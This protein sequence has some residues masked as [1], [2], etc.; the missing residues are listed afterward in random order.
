MTWRA[1][2][3][4]MMNENPPGDVVTRLHAPR[5]PAPP[6]AGCEDTRRWVRRV[7]LAW[8]C[9]ACGTRFEPPVERTGERLASDPWVDLD[10]VVKFA[11]VFEGKGLDYQAI[12]DMSPPGVVAPGSKSVGRITELADAV[13]TRHQMTSGGPVK[14]GRPD[15]VDANSSEFSR[16]VRCL[17]RLDMMAA[18]AEGSKHLAVLMLAGWWHGQESRDRWGLS[19]EDDAAMGH[20]SWASFVE[21]MSRELGHETASTLSRPSALGFDWYI[22]TMCANPFLR[23]LWLAQG[24]LGLA[25][26]RTSGR[27]WLENAVDAYRSLP[28]QPPAA[29]TG[30]IFLPDVRRV[31]GRTTGLVLAEVKEAW[32][33]RIH[34]RHVK[35]RTMLIRRAAEMRAA[36]GSV[37]A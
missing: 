18:T 19:T 14:D 9:W 1:D 37:A 28:D 2:A 20:G 10:A 23:A 35:T 24:L 21:R 22:G 6:C 36:L 34:E 29:T 8:T 15:F 30:R 3:G 13:Y 7:G 12:S 32:R 33:D 11:E 4:A 17:R 27:L 5:P 16:A 31:L 26:A 25:A